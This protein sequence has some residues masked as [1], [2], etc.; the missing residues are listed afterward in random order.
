MKKLVL[1]LFLCL[2]IF[3]IGCSNKV[4][5]EEEALSKNEIAQNYLTIKG[6]TGNF[7]ATT[8]F[9][10]NE[11]GNISVKSYND[12]I[13]SLES[14]NVLIEND[15]NISDEMKTEL[16]EIN[17]PLIDYCNARINDDK[18]NEGYY[19]SIG[20]ENQFKDKYNMD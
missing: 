3:F 11:T 17:K 1:G 7:I 9:D 20:M 19:K 12:A 10:D 8:S 18:T 5:K 4:E 15:S 13:R 14:L 2:S 16:I 6:M